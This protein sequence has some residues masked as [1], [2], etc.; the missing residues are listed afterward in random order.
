MYTIRFFT[1]AS[2]FFFSSIAPAQNFE[3]TWNEFL[4]NNKIV[5]MSRLPK[6]NKQY[7]KEEYAQFLLMSTN[8]CFC[9]SLIEKSETLMAELNAMDEDIYE[10]IDGY[11]V[12]KM[13]LEKKIEAYYA[14]DEIWKRFLKTKDVTVEELEE[15]YPPSTICEKQTLV[16][17]SYMTSHFYLCD[18]DIEK[19]KNTFENRTL[20]IAEKTT[21]KMKDV[22]GLT[23]EVKKM[24][25][26]YQII[27]KLDRAWE[28][29]EET[30]ES[31]GFDIDLP[32]FDCNPIPNMKAFILKG[33]ADPCYEGQEML[34][35]IEKLQTKSG[36]TPYRALR[37]EI[38]NLKARVESNDDNIT[39]LNRA[40]K[41]FLKDE[42]VTDT[43]YGHEYCE[44][45][46]MIRALI[47][48]GYAY[49]CDL[50]K[51]NL[52]T[53]DSL[54]R[55]MKKPLKQ[56]TIEKIDELAILVEKYGENKGEVDRLWKKFIANND[57]LDEDFISTELY[58]DNIDQVKDWVMK[59]LNAPCKEGFGYLQRIERFNET[60]DFKF[61]EELECRV[62]R[63]RV[64]IWDCRREAFL[65]LAKLEAPDTYEER[66]AELLVKANME[67]ERPEVCE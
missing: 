18:G 41:A 59:G 1:L 19:S 17:Y 11:K 64:Q 39:D 36:V 28:D 12:K 42:K 44:I 26:Y 7:Q 32:V 55:R 58:C 13:D 31:P 53:I 66:L 37:E 56:S 33:A 20:K 60:F 3:E 27:P 34:D 22:R 10:S 6:P 57:V 24:K 45:E 54:E 51:D 43:N 49:T 50:A 2:L 30:G 65:E 4:V 35:K 21:L 23:P 38:K 14:I 52:K 46:P 15:V 25:K 67:T 63:L 47:L 29:Y 62:Q 61:Y 5:N 48:D 16:K 8:N 9:Q 40:W